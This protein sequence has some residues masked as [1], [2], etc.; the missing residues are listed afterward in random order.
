MG[1][2]EQMWVFI[3]SRKNRKKKNLEEG[4][5]A[6]ALHYSSGVRRLLCPKLVQLGTV[7]LAVCVECKRFYEK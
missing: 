7:C 2:Y 4:G 1:K 5:G 6:S 3:L